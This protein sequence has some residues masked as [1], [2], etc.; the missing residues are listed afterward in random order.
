MANKFVG[1]AIGQT[2]MATWTST[3]QNAVKDLPAVGEAIGA[4]AGPNFV[5]N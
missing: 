2:A 1:W 5:M 4:F 3:A